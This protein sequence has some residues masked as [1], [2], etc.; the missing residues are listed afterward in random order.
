L[1]Y[2]Q[3]G[4]SMED[5]YRRRMD[6]SPGVSDARTRHVKVSLKFTFAST[7]KS[8]ST[9]FSLF[10]YIHLSQCWELLEGALRYCR[11]VSLKSRAQPEALLFQES[12][13]LTT[14]HS[15]PEA[16]TR[17]ANGDNKMPPSLNRR[18]VSVS[19]PSQTTTVPSL[20]SPNWV[21][22]SWSAKELSRL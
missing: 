13:G 18:R 16:C 5:V 22:D 8:T 7:C 12:Q 20:P 21:R 3:D 19:S 6:A 9:C 1:Q 11:A 4:R 15:S 14:Q 2:G 10:V 17:P